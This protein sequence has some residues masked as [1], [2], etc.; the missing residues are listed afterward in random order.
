MNKK[1]PIILAIA[2]SYDTFR[3]H[4]SRANLPYSGFKY[5][6]NPTQ[7]IRGEADCQLWVFDSCPDKVDSVIDYCHSHNIELYYPSPD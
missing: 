4:C 5:L 7:D 3:A 1:E 2:G 6:S